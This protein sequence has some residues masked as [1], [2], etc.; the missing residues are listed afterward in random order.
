MVVI[1]ILAIV[2]IKIHP[3]TSWDGQ[4]DGLFLSYNFKIM[5]CYYLYW[6]F[7]K[8]IQQHSTPVAYVNSIGKHIKKCSNKYRDV[9]KVF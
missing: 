5:L 1:W 6:F 2:N 7:D 8:I 4:F 3:D 9:N